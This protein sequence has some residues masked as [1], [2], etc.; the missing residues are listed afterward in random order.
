MT[1]ILGVI[2]DVMLLSAILILRDA[3]KDAKD[4]L[5]VPEAPINCLTIV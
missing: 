4:N 5:T 1:P 2:V 3:F